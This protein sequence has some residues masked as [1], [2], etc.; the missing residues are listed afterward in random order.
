[1]FTKLY[2]FSIVCACL[3][4]ADINNESRDCSNV[5]AV[6]FRLRQ[7]SDF[8]SVAC[9]AAAKRGLFFSKL[10]SSINSA[11]FVD[12]T[13]AAATKLYTLNNS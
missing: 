8:V 2:F 7:Y 4:E 10:L 11:Q 1:M 5:S 6:R 3:I 9:V 12:V 13:A